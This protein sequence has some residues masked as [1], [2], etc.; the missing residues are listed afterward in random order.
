MFPVSSSRFWR[1]IPHVVCANW[2]L[3]RGAYLCCA[4]MCLW[5]CGCSRVLIVVT[6]CPRG[7]RLLVCFTNGVC[8]F[9]PLHIE[10]RCLSPVWHETLEIPVSTAMTLV[11]VSQSAFMGC[12]VGLAWR[13]SSIYGWLTEVFFLDNQLTD[14]CGEGSAKARFPL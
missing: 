14:T 4:C 9:D 6:W 5:L 1:G 7:L 12:G 13:L 2:M 8:A 10:S 11:S 3:L